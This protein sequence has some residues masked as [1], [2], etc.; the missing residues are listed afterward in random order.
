MKKLNLIIYGVTGTIGSSTLSVINQNKHLFNIEGITCNRNLKKLLLIA[1]RY[2]IKKIGFNANIEKL[3]KN[4]FKGFKVYDNITKFDNMVSNKTDVVI[5][6]ISGLSSLHLL[7]EL[8]KKGKKIGIANKECIISYGK[9]IIKI[10]NKYETDLIP[11]DSEHNSIYHLLKIN[12]HDIKT[13][14]LTATGGPFLNLSQNKLKLIKPHQALKHPIWKMGQKISIDSSTMMNKALEIIEAKY[15]FN[16]K[17]E[18]I[19]AVVH[20]QAI[21]H[22]LINYNNGASS[23]LMYQPDMKVPIS[24]LLLNF[25]QYSKKT[26]K[27]DLKTLSSLNFYPVDIKKFPA[28]KLVYEVMKM[29]GLAPNVFNYLNEILV[30]HFLDKKICF[31]DIIDLNKLNLELTFSKNSNIPNPK[32]E[33]IKNINSW[34]DKNIYIR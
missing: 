17:D 23:A 6:A 20:P 33:D 19:D 29:D 32:L 27:V 26:K 21:V 11:L 28:M 25:K 22:S 34:I 4:K 3:D 12:S 2:K 15:L 16:L 13:V 7:L 1:N 8:L 30:Q 31:T 5:Y 9:K 18:Q 14:T 24:S 10:A